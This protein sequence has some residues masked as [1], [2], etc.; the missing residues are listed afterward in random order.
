MNPKNVIPI[1]SNVG[2]RQP[3]RKEDVLLVQAALKHLRPRGPRRSYYDG[4]LDGRAGPKTSD[5]IL[6]FQGDQRLQADGRICPNSPCLR[7]ISDEVRRSLPPVPRSQRPSL[8][9]DGR[10]LC[11]KGK[12]FNG[13][14]WNAV[15]GAPGF[16]RPEHQEIE[17]RGPIP[18]GLY[19]VRQDEHQRIDDEPLFERL[20]HRWDKFQEWSAKNRETNWPGGTSAWGRNRIWLRPK[21]GTNTFGRTDFSI[22]GGDYPGSGG[23]VD[24]TNHMSDFVKHFTSY[25]ADMDLVVK[26]R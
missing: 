10:R 1:R 23:C 6:A 5:A 25:G 14:C 17:W 4:R 21:S 9:F 18:E 24:L 19:R 20:L 15:S 26:Y 11:W 8:T 22:H 16:Q 13:K 7:R 2:L 12:P 3:N